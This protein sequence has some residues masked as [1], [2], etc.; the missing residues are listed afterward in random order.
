ME[1]KNEYDS[2]EPKV[3]SRFS[4]AILGCLAIGIGIGSQLPINL[5]ETVI[6]GGVVALAFYQYRTRRIIRRYM[7]QNEMCRIAAEERLVQHVTA[8]EKVRDREP[9]AV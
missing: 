6:V 2:A 1:K 3:I 8:P 9:Q 5:G 7:Q 4:L